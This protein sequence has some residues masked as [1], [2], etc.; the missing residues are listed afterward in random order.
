[1]PRMKAEWMRIYT[2]YLKDIERMNILI[3]LNFKVKQTH[4]KKINSHRGLNIHLSEYSDNIHLTEQVTYKSFTM[5]W[6]QCTCQLSQ[7]KT[8]G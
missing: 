2:L 1:M 6:A 8:G 3:P 5:S 4:F 7:D